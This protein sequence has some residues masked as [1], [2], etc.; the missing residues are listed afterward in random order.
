MDKLCRCGNKVYTEYPKIKIR[1]KLVFQED[2]LV[3]AL[4]RNC[5]EV[6]VL[7]LDLNKSS[8]K[9]DVKVYVP[10]E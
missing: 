2:G 9:T 4:C 1:S 3:K 7:P 8:S 5:K 10:T 6:H